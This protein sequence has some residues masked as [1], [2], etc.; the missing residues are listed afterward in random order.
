MSRA[1]VLGGG[2]LTGIAWEAG[3][4]AGLADGGV[5]VLH[6]DAVIGTSAGAVVGARLLDDGGALALFDTL[7]AD[8]PLARRRQLESVAGRLPMRVARASRT[9]GLGWLDSAGVIAV[10]L[11]AV[12][13]THDV[14]AFACV[15]PIV[16]S[17]ATGAERD[18]ALRAYAR[19]AGTVTTPVATWVAVWS[20]LLA[21]VDRWPRGLVVTAIDLDAAA[22]LALDSESGV[23]LPMAIAASTALAGLLPPVPIDGHACVDGG[24]LSATNADLAR[25]HDEVLVIAP[26]VRGSL[27]EELGRPGRA[28]ATVL[29]PSLAAAS[30]MGRAL[31]RLDPDRVAAAARAGRD[32]G[33]AAV[34]RL[35][36]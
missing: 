24:T 23:A 32:D 34:R 15:S 13:R 10:L 19:L 33:R 36:G 18:A 12:A 31:G 14:R 16:R 30:T 9:R 7:L 3:V 28:P 26:V 4:L 5:D 8:D 25:D 27:D 17:R 35:S 20:G 11:R 1:L 29:T 22:R 21:T 6:W 2:G